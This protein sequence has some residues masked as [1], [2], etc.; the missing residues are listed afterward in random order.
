M[1]VAQAKGLICVAAAVGAGGDVA[2]DN[3][4]QE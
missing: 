4:V 2:D 1:E 3:F